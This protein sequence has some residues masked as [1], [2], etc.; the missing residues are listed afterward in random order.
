MLTMDV[1]RHRWD[2][3]M[4]ALSTLARTPLGKTDKICLK[5]PKKLFSTKR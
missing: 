3:L 1:L 2:E 5:S 4:V